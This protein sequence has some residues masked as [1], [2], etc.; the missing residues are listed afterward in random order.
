MLLACRL[1]GLSALNLDYGISGARTQFA[2]ADRSAGSDRAARRKP[3]IAKRAVAVS[4][5]CQRVFSAVPA[6]P[7]GQKER[8][9]AKPRPA[10]RRAQRLAGGRLG[11]RRLGKHRRTAESGST[12]V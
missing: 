3:A 12:A 8:L 4:G 11:S 10:S 1:A 7:A 2:N 6:A 5:F 9:P